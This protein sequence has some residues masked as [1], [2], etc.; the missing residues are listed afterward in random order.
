MTHP[1]AAKG[2]LGSELR[3][4][5]VGVSHEGFRLFFPIST[6]YLALFPLLWVLAWD[7]DLPLVRTV[8]P[9]L[10]HAHE[11]LIGGFGAAL[12]G[13][14]TTAAPEWTDTEPPRGRPLW[15]LAGL[16]AVGRVVGL[17]G[18]DGL[19][20]LGALADLG[21]MVALPVWLLWLSWQKR[22]D[23]L[24]PFIFWIGVLIA[25]TATARA[26]FILGEIGLATQAIHLVGV[27]FLGLL[28]LALSRITVPVTNQI[29]DPSERTSPFRPHAG[30]R[31]LAPGLVLVAMAGDV[32]GLSPA[33]SAYLFL[34]AGAAFM[35]RVAEAF[36]GRAAMRAEILML[37]GSSLLAGVGLL[38][39]G[40]ARL[41]APW[42]EVT[43]LHVALMG[44]LGLGVLAVFCIAGL[45]HSGR[46][47]GV[48]GVARLGAI[49]LVAA[50]ALRVQPDL[51]LD[52]PGPLHALASLAWGIGF[53][54]WLWDFWPFLSVV[55]MDTVSVP[56]GNLSQ[57]ENLS[58]VSA[59]SRTWENAAE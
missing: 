39:V 22:T 50:V 41:D 8:P 15:A 38:M 37:A 33:V 7:F 13:F 4:R 34:A 59:L 56:D 10:W 28:G 36:I 49:I 51:G 3:K 1:T 42:S 54:M 40:A 16:W 29:L 11:M 21:W 17:L 52:L 23:R 18:W 30:R 48:P 32:A 43:G 46:S 58:E 2:P 19:G 47:L 5:I 14:I 35:D 57:T 6:L 27:A 55:D 12:L 45:L 9:A 20:A 44:G 31:N 53:L 24:L 26:G 25:C